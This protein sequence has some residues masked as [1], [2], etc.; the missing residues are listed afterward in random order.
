MCYKMWACCYLKQE[1]WSLTKHLSSWSIGWGCQRR[2]SNTEINSWTNSK[3]KLAPAFWFFYERMRARREKEWKSHM[4][5][6]FPETCTA[7]GLHASSIYLL[8]RTKQKA[9]TNL[10][11]SFQLTSCKLATCKHSTYTGRHM[12]TPSG[13]ERADLQDRKTSPSHVLSLCLSRSV[14]WGKRV[15]WVCYTHTRGL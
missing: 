2:G 8:L 1:D 3:S 15:V 11:V 6:L 7:H 4:S 14:G 13:K 9:S 5:W 12:H 10:L